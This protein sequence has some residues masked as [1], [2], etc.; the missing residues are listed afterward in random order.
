MFPTLNA[1]NTKADIFYRPQIK[2]VISNSNFSKY[3]TVY[4]EFVS[5]VQN[6]L[7]IEDYP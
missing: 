2:K 5:V 6:F 3:M 1:E 4:N 7:G